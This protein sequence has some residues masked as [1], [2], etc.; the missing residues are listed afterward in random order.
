MDLEV[1][2]RKAKLTITNFSIKTVFNPP[3]LDI[4]GVRGFSE[5]D[6]V[7]INGQNSK[8]ISTNI[9]KINQTIH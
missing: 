6:T 9:S 2:Q 3:V 7:S 5:I 1:V 4:K 8:K